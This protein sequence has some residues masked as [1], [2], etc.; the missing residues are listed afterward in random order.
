[1]CW[2]RDLKKDKFLLHAFLIIEDSGRQ[3][4]RTHNSTNVSNCAK[5]NSRAPLFSS[6]KLHVQRHEQTDRRNLCFPIFFF[7]APEDLT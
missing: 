3:L 2:G 5:K 1:M 7:A 6:K 4:R